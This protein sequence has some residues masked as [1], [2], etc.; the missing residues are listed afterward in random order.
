MTTGGADGS[1]IR[2]SGCFPFHP[3]IVPVRSTRIVSRS[4]RRFVA[5]SAS[6]RPWLKVSSVLLDRTGLGRDPNAWGVIGKGV[7]GR[8]LYEVE[9]SRRRETF[10]PSVSRTEAPVSRA[11]LPAI[12]C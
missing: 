4:Q 9:D 12:S 8:R 1:M 11:S 10:Y 5:C 2:M 7:Q 3:A 6:A